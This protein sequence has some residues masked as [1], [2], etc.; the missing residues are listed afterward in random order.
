MKLRRSLKRSN[1]GYFCTNGG[2]RNTAS[3]L[4]MFTKLFLDNLSINLQCIL[5]LPFNAHK[6]HQSNLIAMCLIQAIKKIPK[7]QSEIKYQNHW[8]IVSKR[9]FVAPSTLFCPLA[10]PFR[11]VVSRWM[12]NYFARV[13][14]CRTLFFLVCCLEYEWSERDGR[15]NRARKK[16]EQ[17]VA[18][19]EG[20]QWILIKSL[21]C[22]WFDCFTMK[23]KPINTTLTWCSICSVFFMFISN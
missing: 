15:A 9:I 16:K 8:I 18:K 7:T 6:Y 19:I 2:E 5:L 21:K 13:V 11:F 1:N 22:D 10:L 4:S 23:R 3:S 20:N 14:V 12:Q 17:L